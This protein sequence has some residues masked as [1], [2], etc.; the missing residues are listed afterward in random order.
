ME[1]PRTIFTHDYD[2]LRLKEGINELAEAVLCTMGPE[3][4]TVIIPDRENGEYKITKDGVSVTKA[5][6]F[7]DPIKNIGAQ[8]IKEVAENT[9]KQAGDGTTTSICLANAFINKGF[10]LELGAR[11]TLEELEFLL[12]SAIHKLHEYKE[13]IKSVKDVATIAANG[14]K[15]IGTLIEDAFKIAKTVKVEYGHT[16]INYDLLTVD[17]MKLNTGFFDP[18]FINDGPG[19]AIDYNNAKLIIIPG[20]LNSLKPISNYIKS[21]DSETPVII[22][23]DHFS[24]QV[25]RVLKDNYNRGAIITGLVKSPGHAEHRQNLISDL[26][27]AIGA[28]HDRQNGYYAGDINSIRVTRESTI[29]SYNRNENLDLL[30]NDY[31]EAYKRL[32][33]DYDKELMQQRI[34]NLEGSMAII[35]V[36]GK[37]E[38]EMKERFD[39]VEDAVLA[40]QCAIEDG[41]IPG[42]GIPLARISTELEKYKFASCLRAPYDTMISNGLQL[43]HYNSKLYLSRGI[44]DPYKVTKVAL[45]NA[46]SVAKTILGTEAIVL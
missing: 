17:G 4:S 31:K 15:V 6:R 9:V 28:N 11:E 27:V 34:D 7:E 41:I 46:V 35:V 2:K 29:I 25:L 36:G 24:G 12:A 14:D 21:L 30:L 5:V 3:G 20:K 22:M 8:L 39:R 43:N 40:T 1:Y 37:S 33:K 38:V 19:Q 45:Q 23:A 16:G 13:D 18:A 44:V 26:A 42:A 10:E 32:K